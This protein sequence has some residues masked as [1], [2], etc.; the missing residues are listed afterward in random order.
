M[1]LHVYQNGVEIV[2]QA[3][4]ENLVIEESADRGTIATW[5]FP[6]DDPNGTQTLTAH[7]PI[8]VIESASLFGQT[9]AYGFLTQR[10]VARSD[11]SLTSNA[12]AWSPTIVDLNAIL[13]FK[14][15]RT[16]TFHH[17]RPA[18]T[19]LDR[20][21]WLLLS[22]ASGVGVLPQLHGNVTMPSTGGVSMTANDYAGQ[23]PGDVLND[24]SQASGRTYFV[25]YDQTNGPSL[26]YHKPSNSALTSGISVSNFPGE[27]NNT[28]VFA[29]FG[30]AELRLDPS[31]FYSGV[32]MPYS[33]GSVYAL[34]SNRQIAR[35]VVAPTANTHSRTAALAKANRLLTD[36]QSE[37][38][39]LTF[40]IRVPNT[41][42]NAVIA[43]QRILVKFSHLPSFTSSTYV[44]VSHRTIKP[45]AGT[46]LTSFDV[47]LE[48]VDPIMTR[49]GSAPVNSTVWPAAQEPFVPDAGATI[50]FIQKANSGVLSSMTTIVPVTATF[51]APAAAGNLLVASVF[52]NIDAVAAGLR[53]ATPSGW[54]LGDE[55]SES[56]TA[57]VVI[58][59][60][61]IAAGGETA[62]SFYL[63]TGGAGSY[64][65]GVIISEYH[66]PATFDVQNDN[67]TGPGVLS[68]NLPLIAPTSVAPILLYYGLNTHTVDTDAAGF[69]N[70][71]RLNSGNSWTA[72]YQIVASPSGSYAGAFTLALTT[73]AA[74]AVQALYLS[75]GDGPLQGQP[76]TT[77]SST[78]PSGSAVTTTY[79]Y[80]SKSL[81]VTVNGILQN[82]TETD[83]NAGAFDLGF[84]P[85]AGVDV[86]NV[87][88][89]AAVASTATPGN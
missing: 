4:I 32:Y 41:H 20:V 79:P 80:A 61:A 55:S 11:T 64:G 88:Y 81:L 27:A 8:T 28:T 15:I 36:Y 42:I 40:T 69:T 56:V 72:G 84:V 77:D 25:Y 66:G 48:C 86:V 89:V 43:G 87:R 2:S 38:G 37:E 7:Y 54:T 12:R 35:D 3:F 31:H 70:L 45:A 16:Q 46:N 9:V 21:H 30:D 62:I 14:V 52:M 82:V 76:V 18:E 17:K 51:G 53:P 44:R 83:P 57:G 29:P 47:T 26:F 6:V 73:Y 65:A 39:T 63:Q 33:G 10:G 1:S 24:C 67:V 74:A 85:R 50:T 5:S 34:T 71:Y 19:D 49:Q 13:G 58:N 22:S 23:F 59:Y 60:S 75:G 78:T 68:G